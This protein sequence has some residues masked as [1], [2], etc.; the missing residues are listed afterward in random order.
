M[1]KNNGCRRTWRIANLRICGNTNRGYSA[2]VFCAILAVVL[3][4]SFAL[5]A[6]ASQYVVDP[7]HP[8][9]SDENAGTEESPFSSIDRALKALKAQDTV[10]IKAGSNPAVL[11][12]QTAATPGTRPTEVKL[13]PKKPIDYAPMAIAAL[14]TLCVL[15]YFLIIQPRRKRRSLLQALR[16]I[17]ADDRASFEQADD[18]LNTALTAGLRAKDIAEARFALAYVRARLG[19]FAEA[20]AVLADLITR[21]KCDPETLYL[22]LWLNSRQSEYERIERAYE[23]H[24][25]ELGNLLQ[26]KLIVGIAL[27]Y[28]AR[29]LWSRRQVSGA[30]HYF[31]RLKELDVLQDQIPSH[32][33]DQQVMFGI[34]ALF[35]DDHEEA[36]KHFTGAV[37]SAKKDNRSAV[38]GNLGLLLCGWHKNE[39]P[40]VDNPLGAVLAEMES[41]ETVRIICNSCK[42]EQRIHKKRL[43]K[44]VICVGCKGEFATPAPKAKADTSETP[45][46]SLGDEKRLSD[47]ELLVRNVMLW[48]AVSLIYTWIGLPP[49]RG[50]PADQKDH[51]FLRLDKVLALDPEMGDPYLLAG[52]IRYYAAADESERE[53]ALKLL[54]KAAEMDVHLPEILNLIDRERRLADFQRDTLKR[55]LAEANKYLTDRTV[56]THLRD[57]LRERLSRFSAFKDPGEIDLE[58][59]E[60]DIAPSVKDI[61]ARG[62]LLHSRLKSIV[63]PKLRDIGDTDAANVIEKLLGRLDRGTIVLKKRTERIEE[64]EYNLLA[65]VAEFLIPEDGE[66][67]SGDGSKPDVGG[68]DSK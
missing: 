50:F 66:N 52:L 62:S 12:G 44:K 14:V 17:E 8:K 4:M 16:I 9:A 5:T 67:E 37:E 10:L 54:E 25:A 32:I 65:Q 24:S 56:P 68:E 48:H 26:T 63:K 21:G 36:R 53:E 64:T 19:R 27:L 33:D 42:H 7:N 60:P 29:I 28:Q 47:D 38:P 23:Q 2:S 1:L 46:G 30:L 51:L 41:Q 59:G 43:G 40:D 11:T 55:Y 35:E 58:K 13:P 15:V 18:L 39:T 31:E 6:C 3:L 20:S 57:Q 22:S 49:K 45:N 34:V 61:Q